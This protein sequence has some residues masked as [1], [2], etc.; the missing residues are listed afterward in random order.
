MKYVNDV[1]HSVD[2]MSRLHDLAYEHNTAVLEKDV[3]LGKHVVVENNVMKRDK[4]PE[5][6]VDESVKDP[7]TKG[8]QNNEVNAVDVVEFT[9]IQNE[10]DNVLRENDK[11]KE[12]LDRAKSERDL[13]KQRAD[14]TSHL[15]GVAQEAKSDDPNQ[16][17]DLKEVYDKMIQDLTQRVNEKSTPEDH[18]SFIQMY[19]EEISSIRGRI[20]RMENA[21]IRDNEFIQSAYEKTMSLK[22]ENDELL[23]E[24]K[25]INEQLQTNVANSEPISDLPSHKHP[26]YRKISSL[27]TE[28]Q[29][30]QNNYTDGHKERIH[31]LELLID[32]LKADSLKL[33]EQLKDKELDDKDKE[34][35]EHCD[36]DSSNSD[37]KIVS[38]HKSD[39]DSPDFNKKD[40]EGSETKPKLSREQ[41]KTVFLHVFSYMIKSNE[42]RHKNQC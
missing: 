29:N 40:N 17:I 42:G 35:A 31:D 8:V 15:V 9:N 27:L 3:G 10:A 14:E 18:D 32:N 20:N 33:K 37:S 34:Q 6:G 30:Q 38:D 23:K 41:Q 13:A 22:R 1:K 21:I 26:N 36:S 24:I 28:F 5:I 25:S 4:T 2:D 11:L 16:P 12:K 19:Y 7:N 39:S